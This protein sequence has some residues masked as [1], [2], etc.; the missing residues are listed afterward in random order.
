MG[1]DTG[2]SEPFTSTP[3]LGPSTLHVQLYSTGMDTFTPTSPTTIQYLMDLSR[4]PQPV[5]GK[6]PGLSQVH[7]GRRFWNTSTHHLAPSGHK[8][9]LSNPENN[10]F[11][12]SRSERLSEGSLFL[13]E[14]EKLRPISSTGISGSRGSARMRE[15]LS[16]KPQNLRK[17][18]NMR[19]VEKT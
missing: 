6:P 16:D 15:A 4:I 8:K 13:L 1:K 7:T 2:S 3:I 5:K 11:W 18:E 9:G 12:E 17:V 14:T 19:V 10:E